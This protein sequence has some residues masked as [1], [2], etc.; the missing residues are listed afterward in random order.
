MKPALPRTL[1]SCLRIGV[2][3]AVSTPA[4]R[5]DSD[6]CG[7][8]VSASSSWI[9]ARFVMD[10]QVVVLMSLARTDPHSR[11]PITANCCRCGRIKTWCDLGRSH[12]PKLEADLVLL[13]QDALASPVGNEPPAAPLQCCYQLLESDRRQ[14]HHQGPS[15]SPPG[16]PCSPT[17]T[18]PLKGQVIP[19]RNSATKMLLGQQ[20]WRAILLLGFSLHVI[21]LLSPRLL[22]SA[23]DIFLESPNFRITGLAD[24]E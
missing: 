7:E 9:M 1:T 11:H 18:R 20:G 23:R 14:E 13:D 8:Y 5:D 6:C 22:R 2:I 19:R 16:G 10:S 17:I 4:V 15:T 24:E 12:C 3:S 21:T